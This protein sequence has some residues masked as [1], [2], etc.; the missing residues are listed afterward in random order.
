MAA[1]QKRR[2]K[3][4]VCDLPELIDGGPIARGGPSKEVC[5]V[6]AARYHHHRDLGSC[7]DCARVRGPQHA[8][9]NRVRRRILAIISDGSIKRR[10]QQALPLARA[11]IISFEAA[12]LRLDGIPV[13][14][15]AVPCVI[16]A[17]I[18]PWNQPVRRPYRRDEA[19][20]KFH[21]CD[22]YNDRDVGIS[23]APS[24]SL[25]HGVAI[26]GPDRYPVQQSH[27]Q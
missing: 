7:R 3:V 10:E 26:R 11:M 16:A 8:L 1:I 27:R 4:F 17:A 14:N 23:C 2:Q 22:E 9:D 20:C 12:V 18:L 13:S 6:A 24:A 21:N 15:A 19:A 25:R 5:H